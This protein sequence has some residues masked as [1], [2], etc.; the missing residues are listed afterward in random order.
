MG[1]LWRRWLRS[2]TRKAGRTAARRANWALNPLMWPML[3]FLALRGFIR[4]LG[5]PKGG[6][7]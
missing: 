5:K 1:D 3:P 7:I 6:A 4:W 2:K